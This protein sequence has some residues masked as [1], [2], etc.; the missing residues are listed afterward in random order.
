[1]PQKK[2]AA[3]K[4]QRRARELRS[5]IDRLTGKSSSP[6]PDRPESPA[7]FVHRRMAELDKENRNRKFRKP[8]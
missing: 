1:V 4:R 5:E 8:I 7:A 2:S 3:G 6:A